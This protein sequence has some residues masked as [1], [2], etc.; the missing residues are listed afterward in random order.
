MSGSA[1]LVLF[2][3]TGSI[4]DSTL[5]VLRK[6]RDNMQLVGIACNS[7]SAKLLKIAREFDVQHLAIFDEQACEQTAH[8]PDLPENTTLHG[9]MDGLLHLA[10]LPEATH[11]LFAMVGVTGLCPALAA[12]E[13]GKTLILANKE[14]LVM[15]GELITRAARKHGASLVPADSEHNAIHQCLQGASHAEIARILLTASGGTFRNASSEEMATATPEDALHHPNWD[16]GPKVTIDSSTMANK[17]LEIIETRWLFDVQ[18]NQI[19][20]I[21]HPQS[22]VHSMVEY[23]DGSIIAQLSPPDMTFAIQNAL[24]HPARH[25]RI[26]ETLDFTQT[27]QLDFHPPDEQRFPCLRLAREALEA[28]GGA[29]LV[30]NAANEVAVQAFID[31]KISFLQIPQAIESTLEKMPAR[32]PDNL[33]EV[34]D[35]DQFAR[36]LAQ[37][38]IADA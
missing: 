4:G 31:R 17:G 35:A 12:I 15:A 7:N 19:G 29:S 22:I 24:F 9:G 18:P 16:M 6:Y 36:S 1:K 3:A 26:L 14:I 27:L 10:T 37:S 28:G 25:E 20:V 11:S 38:Y 30:F 33:K 34:L 32:H 2:G 13:Q 8:S 23:V 5:K 21:V